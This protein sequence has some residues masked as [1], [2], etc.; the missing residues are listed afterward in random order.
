MLK[1]ITVEIETNKHGMLMTTNE[2]KQYRLS[3]SHSYPVTPTHVEA[4]G[5]EFGKQMLPL[6]KTYGINRTLVTVYGFDDNY[7]TINIK[8]YS[9]EQMDGKLYIMLRPYNGSFGFEVTDEKGFENVKDARKYL[10]N[11]VKNDIANN[12]N[13]ADEKDNPF[14]NKH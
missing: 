9:F 2:I 13:L 8:R 14:T 6:M 11:L 1:S 7:K 12:M 5:K 4:L 3:N 10:V